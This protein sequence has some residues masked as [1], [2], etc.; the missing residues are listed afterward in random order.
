[1]YKTSFSFL[2]HSNAIDVLSMEEQTLAHKKD[3]KK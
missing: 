2:I 1:M 3:S